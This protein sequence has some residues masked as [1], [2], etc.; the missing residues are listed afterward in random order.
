MLKTVVVKPGCEVKLGD[1]R[2]AAGATLTMTAADVLAN[3]DRVV[4]IRSGEC[5][6]ARG[7]RAIHGAGMRTK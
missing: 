6:P 3:A 2:Y 7:D 1:R 4:A 5:G